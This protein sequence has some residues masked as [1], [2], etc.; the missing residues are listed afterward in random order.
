MKKK[1]DLL[2]RQKPARLY[3]RD[4][5]TSKSRLIKSRFNVLPWPL[6]RFW[7]NPGRFAVSEVKVTDLSSPQIEFLSNL[8][9]HSEVCRSRT[10]PNK[11]K[12]TQPKLN[13]A[14]SNANE[15]RKGYISCFFGHHE[16]ETGLPRIQRLDRFRLK[17]AHL[18]WYCYFRIIAHRRFSNFYVVRHALYS[19]G[20]IV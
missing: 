12:S 15:M 14:S 3:K 9:S 6:A 4:V 16:R 10:S 11:N 8:Q 18:G 7:A 19:V 13:L 5:L 2:E 1:L 20:V 17:V